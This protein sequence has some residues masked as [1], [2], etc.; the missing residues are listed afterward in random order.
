M[1]K[2]NSILLRN[3][4]SRTLVDYPNLLTK[5][6]NPTKFYSEL[7]DIWLK[8]VQTAMKEIIKEFTKLA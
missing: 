5:D 6:T 8:E 4:L 2:D 3:W 7:Q 1:P